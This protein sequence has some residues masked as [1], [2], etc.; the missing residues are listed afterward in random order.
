MKWKGSQAEDR[1]VVRDF[2]TLVL[3][4]LEPLLLEW[5]I[6]HDFQPELRFA[7]TVHI[8]FLDGR[9]APII[10][11]G[12]IDIVVRLRHDLP[13]RDLKKGDFVLFDL[14]STK[15]AAYLSATLGQGIF[16]DISFGHWWG[17]RNEPKDFAFIVPAIDEKVVWVDIDDEDR[18]VMLSRIVTMAQSIWADNWAPKIDD[19]GCEYC[20]ARHVCDKF[21]VPMSVD[22]AGTHRSSFNEAAAI[23]AAARETAEREYEEVG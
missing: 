12:G 3:T 10:L 1:I 4:E 7:T 20:E 15:D 14:K 8:P 5:V 21:A 16:Y 17:D 23:R 18:R 13:E 6:P 11:N 2:V 9:A 19:E 22:P